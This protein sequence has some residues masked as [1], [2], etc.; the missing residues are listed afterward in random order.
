MDDEVDLVCYCGFDDCREGASVD[1]D[2]N[3]R[4]PAYWRPVQT[5]MGVGKVNELDVRY[6]F[7]RR[8]SS[9]LIWL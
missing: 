8:Q 1:W 5:E 6:L 7:S 3:F 2:L 4:L 9:Y